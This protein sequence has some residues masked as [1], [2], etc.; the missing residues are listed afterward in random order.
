MCWSRSCWTDVWR[1]SAARRM[2]SPMLVEASA[3]PPRPPGRDLTDNRRNSSP[4]HAADPPASELP[5]CRAGG[6]MSA[7]PRSNRFA[8]VNRGM[9]RGRPARPRS[10][11]RRRINHPPRRVDSPAPVVFTAYRSSFDLPSQRR[12][13]LS[14]LVY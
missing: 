6:V 5:L 4:G 7:A 8:P 1:R 2:S 12:R 10:S 9:S 3:R 13:A 11:G 14:C